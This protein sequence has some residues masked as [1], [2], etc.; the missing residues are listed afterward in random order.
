MKMPSSSQRYAAEDHPWRLAG[1]TPCES[2]T[3]AILKVFKYNPTPTL[4]QLAAAGGA[5][6]ATYNMAIAQLLEDE[7]IQVCAKHPTRYRL[8]E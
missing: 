2:A 5:A 8:R 4:S 3:A 6:D 1:V 7:V